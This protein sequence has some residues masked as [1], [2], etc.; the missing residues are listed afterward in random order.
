MGKFPLEIPRWGWNKGLSGKVKYFPS[1][2]RT[3]G[4]F[5]LFVTDFANASFPVF[6]AIFISPVLQKD[7]L[8]HIPEPWRGEADIPSTQALV[9]PLGSAGWHQDWSRVNTSL[10]SSA[11]VISMKSSSRSEGCSILKAS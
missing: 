3:Q 4:F 8:V 5:P 1:C 7:T 10:R 9:W 6:C 11:F 2:Q